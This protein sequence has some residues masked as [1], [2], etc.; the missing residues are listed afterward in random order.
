M[1][2]QDRQ[3]TMKEAIDFDDLVQMGLQEEG[4]QDTL[5][6][7]NDIYFLFKWKSHLIIITTN[8]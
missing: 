8:L 4:I 6:W 7:R 1:F 3:E 5:G 2:N